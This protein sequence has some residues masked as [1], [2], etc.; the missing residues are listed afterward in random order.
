MDDALRVRGGEPPRDLDRPLRGFARGGRARDE[1]VAQRHALEELHHDIGHVLGAALARR[2]PF[3]AKAADV[4]DRDD[5]RMVESGSCARFTLEAFEPFGVAGHVRR[6]DLH[7]DVAIQSIVVGA[8][9]LAHS[10]CADRA[11]DLVRS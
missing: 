4:I 10:A 8:I 5:V 1:L 11:D 9:D 7:G 2:S 6:Q 3:G